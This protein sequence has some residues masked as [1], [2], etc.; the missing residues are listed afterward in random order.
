MGASVLHRKGIGFN[1]DR[2]NHP[3]L[4]WQVATDFAVFNSVMNFM[5]I[6]YIHS[7]LCPTSLNHTCICAY[8]FF[9]FHFTSSNGYVSRDN[10]V[11]IHTRESN[12]RYQGFAR[13]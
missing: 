7:L 3:D 2:G 4:S 11:T 1:K 5:I 12:G 6:L 13:E 10:Q 8:D 9:K